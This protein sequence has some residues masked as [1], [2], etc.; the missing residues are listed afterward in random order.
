[1]LLHPADFVKHFTQKQ[2]TNLALL[3]L[4]ENYDETVE[5]VAVAQYIRGL[6]GQHIIVKLVCFQ[7][8]EEEAR[9]A[10]QVAEDTAPGS[11]VVRLFCQ[12][13]SLAEE[14]DDQRS[15]NPEGHGYTVGNCY[16]SN[17]ADVV[18]VLKDSF[19]T[20]PTKKS[21]SLWYSMA[22]GSRRS[23]KD[24]TMEDMALSMQTD[25]YYAAYTVSED[26]DEDSKC[27][28]WTQ[29]ILK[30]MEPHAEGAYL[31]DSDFQ[32]RQTMYWGSEQGCRLMEVRRKWDPQG[33]VCGFLD[34]GDRSGTQGLANAP[35]QPKL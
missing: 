29:R 21:F 11:P 9:A 2:D 12:E 6:E 8:S 10:L 1:M 5:I 14:Y 33:V 20:L 18:A 34:E 23:F 35:K 15:A 25:H 26:A 19:T 31:G 16:I 22:P 24:G 13:T 17:D 30:Q 4:A 28:E 7:N 32:V 3:Q 27:H